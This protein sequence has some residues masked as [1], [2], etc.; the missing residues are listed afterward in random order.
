LDITAT[1]PVIQ[2]YLVPSIIG[3]GSYLVSSWVK[4]KNLAF[5]SKSQ[6]QA[7]LDK[8][9]ERL[10]VIRDYIDKKMEAVIK[11]NDLLRER[12]EHLETEVDQLRTEN[13][14]LKAQM[15]A[16]K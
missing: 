6:E 15:K 3:I 14:Q 11:E 4:L 10:N 1:L 12:I 5:K 2:K 16:G 7:F 9:W 8:E 13:L